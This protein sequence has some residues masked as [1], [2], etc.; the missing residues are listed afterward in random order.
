MTATLRLK[1]ITCKKSQ[2][3]LGDELYFTFNGQKI[4]L[5]NMTSG[6]TLALGSGHSFDGASTLFLFENDGDHWFDRDDHLGSHI[7][8]EVT[9][10]DFQLGFDQDGAH[11]IVDVNVAQG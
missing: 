10:G 4:S 6:A 8:T 1:S 9:T 3:V 11:Y 5:P 7:I 2:E